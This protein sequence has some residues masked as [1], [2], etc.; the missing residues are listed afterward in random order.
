MLFRS[1]SPPP[2]PFYAEKFEDDDRVLTAEDVFEALI[3]P[4]V[5]LS[6]VAEGISLAFAVLSLLFLLGFFLFMLFFAVDCLFDHCKAIDAVFSDS[7]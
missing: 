5:K 4:P 3:G 6:P 1:F 7:Q 2:P